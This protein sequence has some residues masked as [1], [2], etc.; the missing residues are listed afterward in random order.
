MRIHSTHHP[1][2]N[3]LWK[4]RSI[5]IT[6]LHV[7]NYNH[8]MLKVLSYKNYK[9]HEIVPG[10]ICKNCNMLIF[11]SVNFYFDKN[12]NGYKNHYS[13]S[14]KA[15]EDLSCSEYIMKSIIE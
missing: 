14:I 9:T 10:L 1:F 8:S 7:Y 2:P 11:G 3:I 13:N 12:C 6:T 5:G 15:E 4:P